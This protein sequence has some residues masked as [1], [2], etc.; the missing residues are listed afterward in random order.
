MS[1]FQLHHGA[2]SGMSFNVQKYIW[3][4]RKVNPGLH[5]CLGCLLILLILWLQSLYHQQP[6]SS[7]VVQLHETRH[8]TVSNL[9]STAHWIVARAYS[10]IQ[11]NIIMLCQC[12]LFTQFPCTSRYCFTARIIASADE[13]QKTNTLLSLTTFLCGCTGSRF[14]TLGR[15]RLSIP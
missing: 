13:I 3:N 15:L 12:Q 2:L 10:H 7:V 5:F 9:I 11:Y 6:N 4:R 14:V 1:N 8:L